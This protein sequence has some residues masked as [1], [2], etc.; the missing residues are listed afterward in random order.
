MARHA[1]MRS[2]VRR[3]LAKHEYPRDAEKKAVELVHAEVFASHA[4]NQ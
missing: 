2:E 1:A 4:A 3:R